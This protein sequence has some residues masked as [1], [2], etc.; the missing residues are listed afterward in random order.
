[1]WIVFRCVAHPDAKHWRGRR[2]FALLDAVVW[3]TL[4]LAALA[5]VHA[6]TGVV[7]WVTTWILL[8]ALVRR[9]Q[10]AWFRNERHQST[11]RR[12]GIPLAAL[13]LLATLIRVVVWLGH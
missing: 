1:M 6:D 4:L 7:G 11:T 9:A 13:V 5:S 8:A 3:P 2:V 12:Y 10:R